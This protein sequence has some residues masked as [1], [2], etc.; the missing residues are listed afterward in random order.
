MKKVY[1]SDNNFVVSSLRDLLEANHIRC[2]IKN[3]YLQ[4]GVGE[5]PVMECWPELWIFEDFQYDKAK[6]LIAGMLDA[7][8]SESW[9]CGCGEHIEGQFGE[10]W[11]CG[12]SRP[13]SQP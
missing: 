9:H 12:E 5:L 8:H 10:C 13:L 6:T 4:G 2:L 3:E 1:S 11:N 7:E